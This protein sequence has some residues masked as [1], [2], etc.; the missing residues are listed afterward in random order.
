MK[1]ESLSVT[2]K[3][4]ARNLSLVKIEKLANVKIIRQHYADLPITYCGYCPLRTRSSEAVFQTFCLHVL[5]ILDSAKNKSDTCTTK[6]ILLSPDTT[7]VDKQLISKTKHQ[8]RTLNL[9]I[10]YY[11]ILPK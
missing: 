11:L 7:R 3:R 5:K 6:L 8:N 10:C 9:A 1:S 2:E 4:N